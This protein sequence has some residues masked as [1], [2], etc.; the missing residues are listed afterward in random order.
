MLHVHVHCCIT[1]SKSIIIVFLYTLAVGD[2]AGGDQNG[3]DEDEA[4][5]DQNGQD[6]DEDEWAEDVQ[7]KK[8]E[9]CTIVIFFFLSRIHVHV[10]LRIV[11][12][13]LVIILSMYM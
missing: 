7:V 4:G 10:V 9:K 3:Q 2:E 6:E 13:L 12:P 5:G 11:L 1:V 8:L